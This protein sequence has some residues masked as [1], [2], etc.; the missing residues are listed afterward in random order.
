MEKFVAFGYSTARKWAFK[1][2]VAAL[3]DQEAA[4]KVI[5]RTQPLEGRKLCWARYRSYQSRLSESRIFW[6]N[7]PS[8][9]FT[10]L[11]YCY[12]LQ[13]TNLVPCL[14]SF[15]SCGC[16]VEKR[17]FKFNVVEVCY[18]IFRINVKFFIETDVSLAL[19]SDCKTWFCIRLIPTNIT[20]SFI[21]VLSIGTKTLT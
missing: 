11:L 5:R 21:F 3:D 1:N 12:V 4:G 9:A 6:F 18:S 8:I 20:L 14:F 10:S 17:N 2:R 15:V 7:C 13:V 19:S 16:L